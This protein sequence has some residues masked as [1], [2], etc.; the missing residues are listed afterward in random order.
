M[1][2]C[3]ISF[4]ITNFVLFC[5]FKP[6][7]LLES[8][9][10]YEYQNIFMRKKKSQ[11]NVQ[12][13]LLWKNPQIF[14]WMNIFINKYS[15]IFEYPNICYTL[16][17]CSWGCSTNSGVIYKQTPCSLRINFVANWVLSQ[18]EFWVLL[19]I[20]FFFSFDT[21]WV[22]GVL[23]QLRFWIVT[24]WVSKFCRNW[25]YIIC[26]QPQNNKNCW[27][28]TAK[29]CDQTITGELKLPQE[30]FSLIDY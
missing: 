20:K 28:K 8:N 6:M 21:I 2:F 26:E 17:Q 4:G 22:F 19:R 3:L 9:I 16:T 12:I 10:P 24:I 27:I 29:Q 30:L 25:W 5:S 23:S 15:N 18:I 1:S 11:M 7:Y 13:Y 14:E